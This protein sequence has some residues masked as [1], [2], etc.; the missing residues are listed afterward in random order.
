M[1]SGPTGYSPGG[2]EHVRALRYAVGEFQRQRLRPG[3][4]GHKQ[5]GQQAPE[6]PGGVYPGHRYGLRLHDRAESGG[7]Q[8]GTRGENY[9]LHGDGR[10]G[11]RRLLR[12]PVHFLPPSDFWDFYQ[13][14][15]GDRSR[16]HIF[17]NLYPALF[18]LLGDRV[19]PGYGNRLRVCGA[20]IFP[21]P[22]GRRDLQDR[23]QLTVYERVPYGIYRHMVGRGLLADPAGVYL[24]GVLCEREMEDEEVVDGLGVCKVR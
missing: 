17:E 8:D 4:V 23:P 20:G 16:G 14:R 6:V 13:R 22:A 9:D 21:G 1:D 19:L 12:L 3:G 10:Y 18:R 5:R 15:G 7:A 11:L 2:A 24:R